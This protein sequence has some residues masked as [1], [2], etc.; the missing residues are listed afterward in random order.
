MLF[1]SQRLMNFFID[2][3]NIPS[4]LIELLQQQYLEAFLS[5]LETEVNLFLNKNKLDDE[6]ERLSDI[7]KKDPSGAELIMEFV[8]YYTNNP[9]IKT[10]VDRHIKSF[11][12]MFNTH[13]HQLIDEDQFQKMHKIIVDDI[14]TYANFRQKI[15]AEI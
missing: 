4:D 12:D 5:F 2:E 14:N 8:N 13:V 11:N 9:D 6:I 3:L 1:A 10:K 15:S 7:G